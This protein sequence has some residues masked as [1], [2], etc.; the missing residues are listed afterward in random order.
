MTFPSDALCGSFLFFL[1]EKTGRFSFVS[2]QQNRPTLL[3][4]VRQKT[5]VRALTSFFLQP[6]TREKKKINQRV[7][8]DL[9]DFKMT[10]SDSYE[11]NHH[12]SS[13]RPC[14]SEAIVTQ[15]SEPVCAS[16]G[17]MANAPLLTAHTEKKLFLYVRE[18]NRGFAAASSSSF[19]CTFLPLP[20]CD[21]F[22]QSQKISPNQFADL[23][24]E[25]LALPFDSVDS[26]SHT[27]TRRHRRKNT[28][29]KTI[30][31]RGKLRR[32]N[33]TLPQVRRGVGCTLPRIRCSFF[34]ESAKNGDGGG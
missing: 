26:L 15:S 3:L 18:T 6:E 32:R 31:S 2:Q 27:R 14:C 17:E 25:N 1:P 28:P 24:I 10:T 8:R 33:R 4:R 13:S 21:F 29:S 19:T 16:I 7:V 30:P 22:L 11:P 5:K 12:T 9:R 20:N 34:A 23:F